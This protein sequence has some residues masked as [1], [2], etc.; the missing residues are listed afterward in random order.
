MVMDYRTQ[1]VNEV[2]TF[3][4]SILAVAFIFA[5]STAATMQGTLVSRVPF[6]RAEIHR[7]RC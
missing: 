5:S 7:S 6:F 3:G 1:Q 2:V 4:M